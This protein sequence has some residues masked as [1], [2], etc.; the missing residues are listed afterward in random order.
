MSNSAGVS[1]KSIAKKLRKQYDHAAVT[2]DGRKV[3]FNELDGHNYPPTYN[4]YTTV[5]VLD[6]I[7]PSTSDE[8]PAIKVGAY[9]AIGCLF[10]QIVIPVK[11][12]VYETNKSRLVSQ[13]GLVI[14]PTTIVIP[15]LTIRSLSKAGNYVFKPD[16]PAMKYAFSVEDGHG[17]AIDNVKSVAVE[18]DRTSSEVVAAQVEL[19]F[20]G[21][22]IPDDEEIAAGVNLLRVA[23]RPNELVI[24]D[25]VKDAVVGTWRAEVI[26]ES[27]RPGN[28][29]EIGKLLIK[30]FGQEH[31]IDTAR[32]KEM[33]V[34]FV[35]TLAPM[36]LTTM[37]PALNV[38]MGAGK[39]LSAVAAAIDKK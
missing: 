8:C 36:V 12:L 25:S 5:K 32:A 13:R 18:F 26:R 2:S 14:G 29:D 3:W 10:D 1:R 16:E 15:G 39:L 22:H 34:D 37:F 23:D 24:D 33:L 4:H 9:S 31:G 30:H 7:L 28:E 11:E 21:E 19:Q 17:R 35:G 20:V 27:E 38:A 6:F